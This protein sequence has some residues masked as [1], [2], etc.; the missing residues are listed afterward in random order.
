MLGVPSVSGVAKWLS[1]IASSILS[2][3]LGGMTDRKNAYLEF[4]P[5]TI[6]PFAV[7]GQTVNI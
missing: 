7:L 3:E 1:T 5:D 6:D 4:Y 2:S